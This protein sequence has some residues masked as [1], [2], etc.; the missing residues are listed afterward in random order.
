[1]LYYWHLA[2]RSLRRGKMFIAL[3]V[4]AIGLG[5]GAS[6]TMLTVVHAMSG[7]PLPS[8]S[9]VLFSPRLDPLPAGYRPAAG[10]DPPNVN[11]TW[12][13][14]MAL[15][16]AHK[17][18]RQAV[19]AGATVVFH[20]QGNQALAFE[21]NG[22]YVTS[23]FFG[24][25]EVPFV[26][27]AGWS[28]QEDESRGRVVVLTRKL[29]DRLLPG[30][31]ALG[32][33]VRIDQNLFRVV[34]VTDAWNPQPM[35]YADPSAKIFGDPDQFFLPLTTAV[36]AQMKINGHFETWRQHEP[37]NKR[38]SPAVTWLQMWVELD[39]SSQVASYKSFLRSYTQAQLV[40]GRYQRGPDYSGLLSL[41][42]V[43]NEEDLVPRD[44]K[45]QLGMSVAFL[46]VCIAN[47][48]ALLL[49]R[50]LRRRREI[51]IRRALGARRIGIVAQ[52]GIEAATIGVVGG[53]LGIGLSFVGV[54]MVRS[55]APDYA[56]VVQIDSWSMAMAVLLSITSAL[57]A[58][59]IPAWRASMTMPGLHLKEG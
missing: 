8:Q 25:F 57:V 53:L 4:I 55:G 59:L 34:G 49:A 20:P 43:L 29:A 26:R 5:V 47:I 45:M 46:I 30:Q 18:R 1:M 50:F 40:A 16:H 9:G 6:I 36:D 23:E 11:L 13:D 37:E 12:P 58:G 15:L 22:H 19:M 44:V 38:T 51:A 54:G 2:L 21:A 39:D 3:M 14:A 28:V 7:D 48:S 52:L 32:A 56:Q 42:R 27:G 31:D 33:L 24:L 41:H 17:A 35:F 10:E